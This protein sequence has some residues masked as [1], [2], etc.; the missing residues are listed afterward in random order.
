M[1]TTVS[2]GSFGFNL[3]SVGGIWSW[4]VRANNVYGGSQ[5]YQVVDVTSP[6]GRLSDS[7]SPIPGDVV[8]AMAGSILDVQGQL[9]PL[10]SLVQGVSSL[11]ITVTEGD[12]P[13]DVAAVPVQ[14]SGA[15]GSF[16]TATA[17]PGA[18]WL[19][20]NPSFL[21]ALGK[22][23]QGNFTIRVLPSTLL[24]NMSPYSGVVSLQDNRIPSTVI[25][26]SVMVTVL[27]R[28][29]FSLSASGISL[30]YSIATMT[31]GIGSG[32][33]LVTNGGPANSLLNFSVGKVNNCSG[34]LQ[35]SPLTVGPLAS[36]GSSLLTFTLMPGLVPGIPGSYVETVQV[37]S[38]NA[39]NSPQSIV[40]TLTVTA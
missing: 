40:V 38:T 12:P 2:G 22:G 39:S 15:F 6:W 13:I 10:L 25:P 19:S 11:M 34:W 28:P 3:V 29:A 30:T 26:I 31:T 7:D 32:T 8:T 36:G 4:T 14:N 16:M 27:P 18:S 9:A 1:G 24:A 35:I 20:A 21:K 5:L 37:S 17:T 33:V 23:E